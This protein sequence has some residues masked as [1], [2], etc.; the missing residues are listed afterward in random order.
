MSSFI[1][2]LWA[3]EIVTVSSD[4]S[5]WVW[6][7]AYHNKTNGPSSNNCQHLVQFI[8]WNYCIMFHS[9]ISWLL[10]LWYDHRLVMQHCIWGWWHCVH[11]NYLVSVSPD[12]ALLAS[13]LVGYLNKTVFIFGDTSVSTLRVV[14]WVLICTKMLM[15]MHVNH[16]TLSL[17]DIGFIFSFCRPAVFLSLAEW[18]HTNQCPWAS[19]VQLMDF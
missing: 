10:W 8:K 18:I 12:H 9:S 3:F 13:F 2:L 5:S 16:Q 15:V 6:D 11:V 4:Y 1:V 19:H 14:F 7:G 17:F